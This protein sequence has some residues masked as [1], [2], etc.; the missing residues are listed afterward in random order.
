MTAGGATCFFISGLAISGL[1]GG[2]WLDG[3]GLASLAGLDRVEDVEDED[4]DKEDTPEDSEAAFL[5]P[6]I[7]LAST[8]TLPLD[9]SSETEMIEVCRPF[10]FSS[11]TTA[12]LFAASKSDLLGW[13]KA[14][15]FLTLSMAVCW[16]SAAGTE[17]LRTTSFMV[18]PK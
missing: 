3:G 10:L 16:P 8:I 11:V 4:E 1:A 13:D 17:D 15:F 6:V 18:C 7:F 2:L 12:T 9:G 14:S 5:L